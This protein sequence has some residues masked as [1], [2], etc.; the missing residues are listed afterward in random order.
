MTKTLTIFFLIHGLLLSAQFVRIDTLKIF[1]SSRDKVLQL[2]MLR[3]PLIRTGNHQTD[4][5]INFDI[6]NKLTNFQNPL[7]SIESSLIKWADEVIIFLDFEVTYNNIGII[8]LNIT[9][10]GCGAYCSSGTEYFNYNVQTGEP[11]SISSVVD[12]TGA[13]RD[14]VFS[15]ASDQYD[16]ELLA[17]KTVK[18][19]DS[20]SLSFYWAIE[21][22]MECRKSI[23][24]ERFALYPNQLEI[25]ETCDLANAIK[26][27]T[28]SIKLRFD[29][30]DIR[31]YLI[32][33]KN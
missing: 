11:L 7:N 12:T 4:S 19:L 25:I 30:N 20:D 1:H 15:Q 33:K 17:L 14:L 6:K 16:E 24:F 29:F 23:D 22:Y 27:L 18:S 28:P 26:N 13:F 10:E 3:Y 8:S 9:A 21:S 2:E 5:L 32:L 31:K